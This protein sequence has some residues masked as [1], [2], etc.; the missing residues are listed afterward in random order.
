MSKSNPSSYLVESPLDEE[1]KTES[2]PPSPSM[3]EQSESVPREASSPGNGEWL[4][5]GIAGQDQLALV[6]TT[7]SSIQ[8]Q[9]SPH[10]LRLMT[11]LDGV[12]IADLSASELASGQN[13]WRDLLAGKT[14]RIDAPFEVLPV[15]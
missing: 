6:R 13:L 8:W 10:Q 9:P 3:V 7:V 2:S 15:D 14:D 1:T 5:L 12:V 11:Q 4:R